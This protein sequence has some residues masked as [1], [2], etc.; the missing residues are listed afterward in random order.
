MKRL[1]AIAAAGC[2]VLLCAYGVLTLYDDNLKVGRMWET[3]AVK[4]HEDPIPVMAPG[5]V[6]HIGG[7]ALMRVA[8]GA[9]AA[10]PPDLDN[11]YAVN[12]GEKAYFKFCVHC[13]GKH[14]DGNATVG[15]S[16]QPLPGDLRSARIQSMDAGKIFREISYGIPGG[17][18]PALASTISVH[19]R[20][21][22]V[23]YV[24]SLGAR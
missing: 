7:E 17:R 4:P 10:V 9:A 11:V 2:V 19:D 5:V 12:G 14:H 22:I 15:Q 1:L 20:W 6:P 21:R 18:Q 13:H 23:A 24:K 3:P 8:H 16:F